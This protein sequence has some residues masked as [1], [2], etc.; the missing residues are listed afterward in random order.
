MWNKC[1]QD[2]F[3]AVLL[4]AYVRLF[5]TPWLQHIRLLGP[6]LS[7]RASSN[8]CPFSKWCDLTV[9]SS[10]APFSF[11]LQSFPESR[12]F[13]AIC[14]FAWG[15]QSTE[16]LA[17]AW[18]LPMNIQD[19]FPFRLT[20]LISLQSRGLSRGFSSTTTRRINSLALSLLYSPTL[21]SV[22]DYWKNHSFNY[23]NV[24]QQSEV[25]TF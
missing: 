21:T 18:V 14:L 7:S 19:W 1:K 25:S 4:L 17:S 22:R 3:V 10:A 23:T 20:G 11:C 8:S 2:I 16:A 9:S 15:G 24:C 6:P 12:S 13:P 5:E